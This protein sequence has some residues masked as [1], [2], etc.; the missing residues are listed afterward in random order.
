ISFSIYYIKAHHLPLDKIADYAA[1]AV[2]D[3]GRKL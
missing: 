2:N 3:K 1:P